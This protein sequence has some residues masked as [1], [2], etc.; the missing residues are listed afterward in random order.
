MRLASTGFAV[1][2]LSLSWVG[3]T[4]AQ[5]LDDPP[6][7][8][9]RLAVMKLKAA[10]VPAEYAEG[11]TETLATSAAKT[12][13]FETISPTQIAS[14]LAFEKRKELL[15]GC[16]EEDCYVQV[17]QAVKAPHLVGGSVAKIGDRLV[18]NL[19]L[20]DAQA[21]TAIKRTERETSSASAL[22]SAARSA[23]TVVLQPLLE[24]RQGYLKV[25]VNV[26]DASLVVDDERRSEGNGQVISLAAGPHVLR[27]NRD[28]FYLATA[29]VFVRPGR[30]TVEEVNLI[31]A[32][33]TIE[34]YERKANLMR[35]G[36]YGTAALAVGAA[37]AGGVFYG[38]ATG[39]KNLVDTY[40]Q[41]LDSERSSVATFDEV[42]SARDSFGT[43]QAVYL[44][45]LGTALVSAGVSLYL[46]ATGDDPG[47]YDEFHSLNGL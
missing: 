10:G 27:V 12:G 9:S 34:N 46:F 15:G 25:A 33:D 2:A 29:D 37:V 20:I 38:R 5:D 22:M 35:W 28:G 44:S 40:T 16:V 26:P 24:A 45:M 8:A 17:A 31:P 14:L 39:D 4:A 36:A 11:L 13:V 30:M 47:R 7:R 1:L 19:V 6:P 3:E 41:A 32:K 23:M 43:N 42:V 21:G 18:L